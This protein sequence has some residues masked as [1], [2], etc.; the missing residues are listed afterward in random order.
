M[1][2]T[3]EAL[4]RTVAVKGL[5]PDVLKGSSIGLMIWYGLISFHFI[6]KN[7][8]EGKRRSLPL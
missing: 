4:M 2:Q 1:L 8:A 5:I 7:K 3:M 6:I